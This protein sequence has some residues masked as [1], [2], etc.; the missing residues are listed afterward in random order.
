M[1]IGTRITLTTAALVLSALGLFGLGVVRLRGDELRADLER[2]T[3]AV[4]GTLG[5]AL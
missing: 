5:V 2:R 1:R 3:R 4:G